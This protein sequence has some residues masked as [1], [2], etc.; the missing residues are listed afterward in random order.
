MAARRCVDCEINWP[1]GTAF[2][3]CGECQKTTIYAGTKQPDMSNAE[4][5]SRWRQ[6]EFR[7]FY[8]GWE[9]E[10]ER[11]GEPSPETQGRLEAREQTR[12]IRKIA[13]GMGS[14][15]G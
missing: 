4:A 12:Q 9:A 2:A 1:S 14:P 15:A 6:A 7:R 10:R 13:A 11:R 3:K 5:L 8:E